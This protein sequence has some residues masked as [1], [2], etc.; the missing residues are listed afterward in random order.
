MLDWICDE[1]LLKFVSD[2]MVM[3][4]F[5]ISLKCVKCNFTNLPLSLNFFE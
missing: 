4:R 1:S 5:L 2:M 3:R